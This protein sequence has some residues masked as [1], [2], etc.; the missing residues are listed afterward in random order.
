MY[1]KAMVLQEFESR[2]E[3]LVEGVFSTAFRGELQPVEIGRKLMREMDL[4]RRVGMG[5]IIAPN[6]FKVYLSPYDV[7]RFAQFE[8][9]FEKELTIA[10][11]THADREGYVFVGP[12][13]VEVMEDGELKRGHFDIETDIVEGSI[14]DETAALELPDGYRVLLNDHPIVL[15]RLSD[16]D[17]VL[18][19][20]NVS[21]RHAEVSRNGQE[22][23]LR[24]LGS[25]NGTLLNGQP[26][27]TGILKD[28]DSVS[29]GT[30]TVRFIY[31]R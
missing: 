11:Q 28:G 2:L 26:V 12:L 10:L 31:T 30:T 13:S 8:D 25:T 16:C 18:H 7:D 3:R 9:A 17:I 19:D 15:G 14:E 5:G 6:E 20:Q 27:T 23:I 24:D 29:L 22:Y 21:R 1:N 4:R